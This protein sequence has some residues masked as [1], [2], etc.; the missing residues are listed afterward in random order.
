MSNILYIY[1]FYFIDY[2]SIIKLNY[3]KTL[4]T[5]HEKQTYR[6]L[7]WYKRAYWKNI[8]SFSQPRKEFALFN[9]SSKQLA[10]FSWRVWNC[11]RCS[12]AWR[13]IIST[14]LNKQLH[15][16]HKYFIRK[17]YYFT[18]RLAC[19]GLARCSSDFCIL[20]ITNFDCLHRFDSGAWQIGERR[21]LLD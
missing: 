3:I 5:T 17:M 14:S 15:N 16:L 11:L 2:F 20:R 10:N 4:K 9:A 8:Y 19:G 1:I 6:V 13:I 18:F 12:K 21:S 7:R